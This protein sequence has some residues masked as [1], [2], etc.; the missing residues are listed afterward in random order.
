MA[1]GVRGWFTFLDSVFRRERRACW[2]WPLA[3]TL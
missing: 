3:V 1:V 2:T